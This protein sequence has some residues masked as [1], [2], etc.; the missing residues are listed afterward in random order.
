[1]GQN[2]TVKKRT[3]SYLTDK[4]NSV[5]IHA[6]RLDNHITPFKKA[7]ARYKGIYEDIYNEKLTNLQATKQASSL[8]NLIRLLI[9]Q[10]HNQNKQERRK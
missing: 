5:R 3:V 9:A 8:L 2:R 1:M 4:Q 10:S 6:S 7:V